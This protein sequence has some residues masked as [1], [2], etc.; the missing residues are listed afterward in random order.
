MFGLAPDTVARRRAAAVGII[1]LGSMGFVPLFGGPGYE[2]ALAAGLILP[3]C[4]ALG[5]ALD[6]L[7][8]VPQDPL[9]DG[10]RSERRATDAYF[11]GLLFGLGLAAVGLAITFLHGLR[12]GFCDAADRKSTRLNS[13]H[14]QKS[15]MPS[16]A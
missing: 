8:R 14:I 10:P 4:A 3:P 16:S 2:S 11:H 13:S 5:V 7:W 9:G 12:V 1:A 15:R 6:T